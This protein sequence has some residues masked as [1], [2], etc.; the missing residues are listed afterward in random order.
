MKGEG[1]VVSD[2]AEGEEGWI[3][4]LFLNGEEAER[5][6]VAESWG[7]SAYIINEVPTRK[8]KQFAKAIWIENISPSL[9]SEIT[10]GLDKRV[11]KFR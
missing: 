3:H 6:G 11:E 7:E 5:G 4:T 1:E 10:Q 8:V 9:V 2:G